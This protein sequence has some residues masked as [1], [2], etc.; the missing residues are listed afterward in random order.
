M[1]K[2]PFEVLIDIERKCRNQAKVIPH[3]EEV[4]EAWQ[5]VGFIAANKYFLTPL[6]EVKEV[7]TTPAITPLPAAAPWFLG[8]ANLRGE[9]LPVT[10][11]GAFLFGNKQ[12]LTPDTR[13]LIVDFER[14]GIGFLVQQVLGVQRFLNKNMQTV[15]EGD[16]AEEIKTHLQ[17]EFVNEVSR[18][19]VLSLKSLSQTGQFYHVVKE[20]GA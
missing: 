12:V 10:D 4:G 17:G 5:G 1:S 16:I 20:A 11:L 8:V 6:T 19:Y 18:W 15:I 13:I 2:D 7:L 14:K 3:L 9:V